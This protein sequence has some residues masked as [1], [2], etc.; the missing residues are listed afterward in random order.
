MGPIRKVLGWTLDEP[1][2]LSEAPLRIS[3]VLRAIPRKYS[4]ING[5]LRGLLEDIRYS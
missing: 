2:C 5:I 1:V 4:M 3:D